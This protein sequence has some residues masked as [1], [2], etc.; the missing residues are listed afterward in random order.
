MMMTIEVLRN[1][2]YTG[3]AMLAGLGCVVLDEMH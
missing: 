1:M 3:S 2:L